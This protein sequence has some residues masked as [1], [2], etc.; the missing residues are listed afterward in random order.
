MPN[1]T[2]SVS[3]ETKRRMDEHPSIRWSN[4]VRSI[5]E[6]KLEDFEEAEKLARKGKLSMED[7]K[8]VSRKIDSAA[9][10]HA[11]ALLNE[12]NS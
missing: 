10:K 11:K 8:E 7:F 6:K 9:S 5:I 12:N 1:L 3:D 2:L 4:V